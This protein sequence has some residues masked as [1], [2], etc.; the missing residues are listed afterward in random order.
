MYSDYRTYG[1]EMAY[2]LQIGNS[3]G[4]SDDYAMSYEPVF[5]M[6]GSSPPSPPSIFSLSST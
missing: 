5:V 1:K 3:L 6:D 4:L 2:K